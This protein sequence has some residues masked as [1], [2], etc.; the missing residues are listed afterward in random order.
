MKKKRKNKYSKVVITC[1]LMTVVLFTI[2]MTVIFCVKGSVPDS[3]V[4]S[5]F[6]FA[7]GEAGIL[8]LIKHGDTKY[9]VDSIVEEEIE[10][11]EE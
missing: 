11:G 3:L 1:L 7:G 10:F 6:V 9:S 5:F 4:T 2:V 8:G